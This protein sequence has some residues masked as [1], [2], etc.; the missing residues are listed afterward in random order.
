MQESSERTMMTKR[1]TD[2]W[3]AAGMEAWSLGFDMWQVITLRTMR[4]AAG[5]A[6]AR[7]ETQRMVEEKVEALGEL[8]WK[9]MTGGI[10]TDPSTGSRQLMRHYSGKVRA[11]RR[12][13]G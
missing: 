3:W 12:R 2:N 9:M 5:G 4:I 13:L 11:N 6:A 1:E 10:S 8:Q 7:T